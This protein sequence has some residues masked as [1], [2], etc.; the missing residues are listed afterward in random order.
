MQLLRHEGRLGGILV[1]RA[2]QVWSP[3]LVVT[4]HSCVPGRAETCAAAAGQTGNAHGSAGSVLADKLSL[5]RQTFMDTYL[6]MPAIF[7]FLWQVR[8][9]W[10]KLQ[11][12]AAVA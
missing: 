2:R 12:H 11:S 9:V 1:L 6:L 7:I 5:L 8:T 4:C 10:C 3:V